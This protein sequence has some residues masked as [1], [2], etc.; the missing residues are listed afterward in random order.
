MLRIFN[1]I[2]FFDVFYCTMRNVSNQ[3]YVILI[4]DNILTRHQK[5]VCD[6]TTVFT[7]QRKSTADLYARRQKV[8]VL[9]YKFS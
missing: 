7:P 4:Q 9:F 1:L 3:K 6:V 5:C 2:F 8:N